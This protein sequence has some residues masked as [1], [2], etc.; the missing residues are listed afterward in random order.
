MPRGPLLWAHHHPVQLCLLN[1]YTHTLPH[2]L[3]IPI[4]ICRGKTRLHFASTQEHTHAHSCRF[5]KICYCS[6]HRCIQVKRFHIFAFS[7]FLWAYR[8]LHSMIVFGF[9]SFLTYVVTWAE[10]GI[11]LFWEFSFEFVT[12]FLF[13]Y[14][15]LYVVY[16]ARL[17]CLTCWEII[18]AWV[19]PFFFIIVIEGVCAIKSSVFC[20]GVFECSGL[21]FSVN[22]GL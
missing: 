6:I 21:P 16:M 17:A 4:P 11:L 13:V 18:L 8:F 9:P 7:I 15:F 3:P 10:N 22:L 5:F 12:L 2:S 19:Q 14:I 20:M 1:I